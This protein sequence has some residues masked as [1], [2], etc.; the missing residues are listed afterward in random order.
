MPTTLEEIGA[1][2]SGITVGSLVLASQAKTLAQGALY[3]MGMELTSGYKAT[4]VVGPGMQYQI[5]NLFLDPATLQT[6]K[7]L[8]GDVLALTENAAK[9]NIG[10]RALTNSPIPG[11]PF[12]PALAIGTTAI[13]GY[14]SYSEGGG[15]AL[16]RFLIEDM[17]AN[18]YGNKAA[19]RS[20]SITTQNVKKVTTAYG[21]NQ[22]AANSLINKTVYGYNTI[23]GS[24]IL[25]RIIPTLGA[26]QGATMGFSIGQGLGEGLS[27]MMF[28]TSSGMGLAGGIMGAGL[29]AK[30]GAALVSNPYALASTALI[31]GGA[32]MMVEP[33]TDI[34]KTGFKH[35]RKR[36]LDYAGDLS[37]F[38][39][40]SSV[41]M[42]QRAVQAMHKSH[43]NARSALGQEASFQHMN[44][45]YFSHLRRL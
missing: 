36:G 9:T 16:G 21:L 10:H 2:S 42:R 5:G 32:S 25:G 23:A 39:T 29:G 4:P 27:S 45:D 8:P 28:G 33:I 35:A 40:N 20:L 34:L 15:E 24:Q 7:A 13:F 41:T 38:N 26:Y 14:Q 31:I 17:Y 11:H 1:A 43:L 3:S 22:S 37:A 18:L 19:E 30:A 44:R 12:I 6:T